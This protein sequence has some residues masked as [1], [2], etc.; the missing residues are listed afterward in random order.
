MKTTLLFN[1]NEGGIITTF[2]VV[3]FTSELTQDPKVLLRKFKS[4]VTKWI[5]S[6][7]TG[8]E[9]WE[10]SGEDFNIGDYASYENDEAL[11]QHLSQLGISV[12]IDLM[13]NVDAVFAYDTVLADVDK[14]E[15][16]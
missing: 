14:I 10:Y 9:A 16:E 2:A 7:D 3:T 13:N 5:N 12:E 4:A 11:N 15:A 6:S 8:A 1:R